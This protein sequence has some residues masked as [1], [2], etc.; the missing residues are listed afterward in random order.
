M[1]ILHPHTYLR[2]TKLELLTPW[3]PTRSWYRGPAGTELARVAGF[4]FDDP[5]GQ[6]GIE[7][8]LVHAGDGHLYQ[9][10]LTYRGSP[11]DGADEFLVGNSEH[12]VLGPRWI[13]DG[14][15]DPAYAGTLASAILT[16]GTGAEE[17]ASIDGRYERRDPTMTVQGG[18]INAESPLVSTIVRVE[19]GDPTLIVADS[20]RLN[21][22]RVVDA[23]AAAPGD[24]TALT[25]VW[26][27]Q[28]APAVLAWAS[29]T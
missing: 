2:P 6:V 18:G 17:L 8:M 29:T 4:R 15:G 11:L 27:G 10:P 9:I 19:D 14:C 5:D 22:R 26:D 23:A 7:T 28:P 25:G 21:I 13:Y 24:A 16:G 12:G 20:V 1:A 3:L